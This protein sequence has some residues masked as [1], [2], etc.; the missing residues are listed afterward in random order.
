MSYIIR[1]SDRELQRKL[2][3]S[4]A[5]LI[6]GAKACGKTESAKQLAKSVLEVDIDP[7]VPLLMDTAPSRLLLGNTPLDDAAANLKK[8]ASVLDTTKVQAPTSLNIITG[9]GISYARKDG[10][11]V[12]SLSSL[13]V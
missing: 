9:T 11:N 13:G 3:A 10:I 6:R 1:V 8:F 4:G 12:V 5:V 7:Q 2:E